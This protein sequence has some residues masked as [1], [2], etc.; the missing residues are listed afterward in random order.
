MNNWAYSEKVEASWHQKETQEEKIQLGKQQFS[1]SER[2]SPFKIYLQ[3]PI[4][5]KLS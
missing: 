4:E 3:T 5:I 2:F 1:S